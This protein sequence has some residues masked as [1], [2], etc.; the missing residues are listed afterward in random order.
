MSVFHTTVVDW[1]ICIVHWHKLVH[2]RTQITSSCFL[3]WLD[4][5]CLKIPEHGWMGL[6]PLLPAG[7]WGSPL[8]ST[9]LWTDSWASKCLPLTQLWD[10]FGKL[11]T[12]STRSLTSRRPSF[13]SWCMMGEVRVLDCWARHDVTMWSLE[14]IV[15]KCPTQLSLPNLPVELSQIRHVC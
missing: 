7:V 11:A 13:W 8:I 10:R 2:W 15:R 14:E 6:L 9:S 5:W 12:I 4:D 1:I 3:I